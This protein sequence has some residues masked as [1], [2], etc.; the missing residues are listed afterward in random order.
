MN[1][2]VL[3]LDDWLFSSLILDQ[4]LVGTIRANDLHYMYDDNFIPFF[5]DFVFMC[6]MG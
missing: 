2:S 3:C 6:G 5:C 1:V 4:N